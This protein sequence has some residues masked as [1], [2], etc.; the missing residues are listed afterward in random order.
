LSGKQLNAAF[1]LTPQV[2]VAILLL[3]LLVTLLA[4]AYPAFYLSSMK[5]IAALKNKVTQGRGT[6]GMRSALVVFQFVISTGLILSI[7]V[8]DEQLTFIREKEIGYNRDNLVVLRES[9][10]LGTNEPVF[11]NQL[12]SDPRVESVTRSAFVP[13]G[14]TNNYM[15][16]IYPGQQ[17]ESV[18]RT[19]VYHID[20]AYLSTMG[21]QLV[22]GRN[23]SE[24]PRL[25]S[26]HVIINET[27]ARVFGLADNPLGQ[28]L[29]ESGTGKRLTVIG[30]VK[31]FHFR[32]LHEAIAPMMM[33]NNP[34]GGLILRTRAADL[35]GLLADLERQWKAFHVEEPFSYAL[36]NELYNETYL[37]EAKMGNIMELFGALTIVVACLGLFGL[38]TFAA[39]QRVKEV[40]IRKVLGANAGEVVTLLSRDL[41]VLVVISFCI[42][43][44]LGY[45]LMDQWLEAF[46]YKTEVQWWMFV[47]AGLATLIIAFVTMSFKTIRSALANPVDA[48]R[49]E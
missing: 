26:L 28:V 23:F 10:L 6:T 49:S 3:G 20:A 21:M 1:L 33:V 36:L 43:F 47:V 22:A 44:P 29:T 16:S 39:E 19:I 11:R 14:P 48:L 32:S 46:V 12:L 40:G 42:A 2:I 7:L 13:A 27:A 8:V 24:E 41:V 37:A 5:P 38:V 17:R 9:H 35:P 25:D 30:V 34:H 45:Y 31:D 18:Y 15:S 4:G